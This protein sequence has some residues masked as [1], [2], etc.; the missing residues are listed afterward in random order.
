MIIKDLA[1]SNNEMAAVAGGTS[2]VAAPYYP[3]GLGLFASHTKIESEKTFSLDVD[4]NE[5]NYFEQTVIAV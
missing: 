1:L 3:W 4:Y 5:R 2:Y